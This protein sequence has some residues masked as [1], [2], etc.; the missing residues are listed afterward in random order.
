MIDVTDE[1]V[2]R[3]SLLL[4]MTLEAKS[5]VPRV[6]HPLI[7]RPMWRMANHASL[8]QR[9]M[10]V[11]KRTTLHGVTLETRFILTEE[12]EAPASERLLN[13]GRGAFHCEADV[14]VMA[15]RATHSPFE[16]GMTMWQ[17]KLRPHFEVTLKTGF[18]RFP[19][20]DNRVIRAAA[21]HVQ[22]ARAVA[23]L[24]ANVFCVLARCL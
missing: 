10:F 11:D 23:G 16:H 22:A 18:G 20:I 24:A 12:S 14:R 1:N 19:R 21:V 15:I 8:A 6:Q 9:F 2:S 7:H 3:L 5:L 17:R 4:E 13:V